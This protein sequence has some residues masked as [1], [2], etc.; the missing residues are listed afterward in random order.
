M[1]SFNSNNA[2]SHSHIVVDRARGRVY[3]FYH[4]YSDHDSDQQ[5][6]RAC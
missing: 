1:L 6:N 3:D 2:C 4:D 5:F